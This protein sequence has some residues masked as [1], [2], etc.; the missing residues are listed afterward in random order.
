MKTNESMTGSVSGMVSFSHK[1]PKNEGI[2]V[3]ISC[4]VYLTIRGTQ[5]IDFEISD[6]SITKQE[7]VFKAGV[8]INN[9]GNVHIRPSGNINI[10]DKK[11]KLAYTAKILEYHPVYA[12]SSAVCFSDKMD[13]K[14]LKP[15]K[16]TA[17]IT[18]NALDKTISKKTEFRL[19]KD[20]SIIQ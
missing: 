14:I 18:I 12:G 1:P 9:N 17:D 4:S 11:N 19:K 15:G 8:Q 13:L 20:G 5:K 7:N 3:K 2:L 10:Y 16:Y 6:I